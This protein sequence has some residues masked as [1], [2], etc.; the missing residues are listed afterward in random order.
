MSVPL[1]HC[2]HFEFLRYICNKYN[3]KKL[4][5]WLS[6]CSVAIH[7]LPFLNYS[8]IP[9]IIVFP[10][11]SSESVDGGCKS[12]GSGEES[13]GSVEVIITSESSSCTCPAASILR[14]PKTKKGKESLERMSG[15]AVRCVLSMVIH[16]FILNAFT[17]WCSLVECS[18]NDPPN[19]IYVPI[20]N[21]VLYFYDS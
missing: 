15:R 6:S 13:G 12:C 14:S 10:Q 8:L 5:C 9:F 21:F 20:W 7:Y 2:D 19:L 1:L 17:A 18:Y 3:K 16:G 11:G 4:H